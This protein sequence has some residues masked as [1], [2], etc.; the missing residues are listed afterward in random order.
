MKVIVHHRGVSYGNIMFDRAYPMRSGRFP[1]DH[2]CA[3]NARPTVFPGGNIPATQDPLGLF[4]ARG[5]FASCFPEGDGIAFDP[6]AGKT[7]AEI[8]TDVRQC[9]GFEV[10]AP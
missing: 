9:F 5:Y 3:G 7:P 8:E 2:P 1:T 10:E 6:P 4:R